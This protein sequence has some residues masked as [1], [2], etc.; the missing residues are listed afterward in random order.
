MDA[1]AIGLSSMKP[2]TSTQFETRSDVHSGR[3]MPVQQIFWTDEFAFLGQPGEEQI[4]AQLFNNYRMNVASDP[5]WQSWLRS[6]Q[7]RLLVIWGKDDPSFQVS[8]AAAYKRDV[9]NAQVL[10]LNAGYFAL[11]TDADKIAMSIDDFFAQ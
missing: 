5:S 6:R 3:H 4:Q 9:K 11:D 2:A 1:Y 7:P 10:V 8:E